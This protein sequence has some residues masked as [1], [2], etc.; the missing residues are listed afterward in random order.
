MNDKY[1]I[2][3]E[4]ETNLMYL[5][6]I[7]TVNSTDNYQLQSLGSYL[8]NSG[9]K[10]PFMGVFPA[11]KMPLLKNN[12]M[13]IVNTDDKS[14]IH[15]VGCY[16]YNNKTYCYDSFDRD[17]RSLSPHWKNK[18]NWVNANND[19]DQSYSAKTCGPYS[20]AWLMSFNIHTTKIISII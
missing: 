16:K 13:C 15:W 19:R 9:K 10:K 7:L 2:L 17:C 8:F 11:D 14:G 4:F 20:V 5:Q 18:H 6:D 12:E 3:K 1:K